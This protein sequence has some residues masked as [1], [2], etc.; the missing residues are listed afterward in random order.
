MP[1]LTSGVVCWSLC[2]GV[3][4]QSS[5][6]VVFMNTTTS[7]SY[8]SGKFTVGRGER[9]CRELWAGERG[10]SGER[11][12]SVWATEV[13]GSSGFWKVHREFT[14]EE[15]IASHSAFSRK[16]APAS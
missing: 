1:K 14:R 6:P 12:E 13:F 16:Q 9:W 10:A 7:Y 11:A 5:K 15:T 3:N 2:C 8:D 4:A